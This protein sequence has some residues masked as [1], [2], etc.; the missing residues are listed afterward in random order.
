[1]LHLAD[2][3]SNAHDAVV[4]YPIRYTAPL[5]QV[6]LSQTQDTHGVVNSEQALLKVGRRNSQGKLGMGCRTLEHSSFQSLAKQLDLLWN[7]KQ[8]D[9]LWNT[10]LV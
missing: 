7:T 1:V 6:P 3:K 8:L 10:I 4:P 2:V 9:L 5:A